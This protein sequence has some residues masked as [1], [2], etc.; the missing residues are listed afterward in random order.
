MTQ[1]ASAIEIDAV[2]FQISCRRFT[3][4]ASITNDRQLPVV[5]EF[6]LRLLAVLERMPVARLRAWFGFSEAELETVL[7]DMRRRGYVEFEGDNVLLSP[8]GREL[9]RSVGYTG[10]PQ[11]VEVT[12][13]VEAVW[14]D[15]VSRNMVRR[16]RTTNADYLVRLAEQENAREFP[17]AFARQAFEENFR[18]Y[19][20]RVRRFPEPDKVSLYSISD[21]EGGPYGYQILPSGLLLDTERM[22][23]RSTFTDMGD[24][25]AGFQKLTVAANNAWQAASPPE[26]TPT[27]AIEFERMTGRDITQLVQSPDDAENWIQAMVE[28]G[29][30]HVGFIPT[31]G[32]TYLAGNL[33]KL[34]DLIATKEGPPSQ[35]DV[36]WLR[37]SGSTWGRTLR[38]AEAIQQIRVA[39]RN[40][41]R[42][43]VRTAL[44]MPR[45]TQRSART[46]HKRLF[47]RGFLLPQGHLPSNLEVLHVPGVAAFVNVH[48]RMGHHS[49]PIGG[50]VTDSKRL[51]RIADRLSPGAVA[52]WDE[53][54]GAKRK[55][56]A[57]A[58]PRSDAQ[59]TDL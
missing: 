26:A 10:V 9:F 51:K 36:T 44:A 13:L 8:A 25:A 3:I 14:F 27:T 54:W 20:K 29:R 7:I 33:T 52:G 16:S 49:V 5:D 23:V 43:E 42:P 53:L 35:I 47:E 2:D 46:Q 17:E 19:A 24:D 41:G 45:L 56:T 11:I 38:V 57:G 40:A 21:V 50:I 32:A 34:I 18:D 31:I 22:R 30:S 12:P 28:I 37:P 55:D 48:L 58:P 15:L 59:A 39:S 6:V 4:R 1:T